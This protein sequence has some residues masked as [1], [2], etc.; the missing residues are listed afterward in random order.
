MK[1]QF[2]FFGEAE[3]VGHTSL[4]A[5]LRP[6]AGIPLVHEKVERHHQLETHASQ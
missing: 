5:Q 6:L 2:C 4:V 3:L 1:D